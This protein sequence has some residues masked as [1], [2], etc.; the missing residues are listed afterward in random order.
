MR[1]RVYLSPDSGA[2][3]A[4]MESDFNEGIGRIM[5]NR[6]LYIK[7]LNSFLNGDYMLKLRNSVEANDPDQIRQEA[8]TLKGVAANLSLN[9]LAAKA[10]DLDHAVRD[11]QLDQVAS[12][13]MLIE[14]S[15]EKTVAEI[16]AYI[17]G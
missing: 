7:L 3:G 14:A 17:Q 6:N 10:S 15:Y 2:A 1:C 13:M 16:H 12:M 8:H 9:G 5:N 4:A 11:G